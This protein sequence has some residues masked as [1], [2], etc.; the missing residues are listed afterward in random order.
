[1]AGFGDSGKELFVRKW[2]LLSSKIGGY[3]RMKLV[4]IFPPELLPTLVRFGL[5]S[6][7]QG[8]TLRPWNRSRNISKYSAPNTVYLLSV[9][10]PRRV[11]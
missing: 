3:F 11:A 10:S 9:N 5:F 4:P 6:N 7:S 8:L 2:G 1:M